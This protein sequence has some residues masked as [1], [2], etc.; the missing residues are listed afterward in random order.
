MAAPLRAGRWEGSRSPAPAGERATERRGMRE[1]EIRERILARFA[2]GDLPLN[3]PVK[4]W[5]GDATKKPCAVCDLLIVAI[6]EIEADG[7][8]GQTRFYHLD[9]YHLV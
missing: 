3:P 2:T 6:S 7:A 9:C 4:T 8:D 1:V 5:G